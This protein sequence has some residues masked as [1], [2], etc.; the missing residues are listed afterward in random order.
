MAGSGGG[1]DVGATVWKGGINAL[2][3]LFL[4]VSTVTAPAAAPIF[5]TLL[6]LTLPFLPGIVFL[7]SCFGLAMML[8]FISNCILKC[9]PRSGA[10]VVS[11]WSQVVT[12]TTAEHVFAS[13]ELRPYSLVALMVW[14]S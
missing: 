12:L 14:R 13:L 8:S 3:P 1:G 11:T 9:S 10:A 6:R 4:D 2:A 5:N 7:A